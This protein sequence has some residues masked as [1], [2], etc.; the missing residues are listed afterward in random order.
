MVQWSASYDVT[1]SG[2]H[3][4]YTGKGQNNASEVE[5]TGELV[6]LST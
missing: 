2:N 3:P 4:L 1:L 5:E 6:L